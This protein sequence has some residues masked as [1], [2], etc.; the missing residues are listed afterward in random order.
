[1]IETLYILAVGWVVAGLVLALL[2]GLSIRLADRR[3]AERAET[4]CVTFRELLDG[5]E[6]DSR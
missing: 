5:A 6:Q 1:M 4:E 3:E 2:I